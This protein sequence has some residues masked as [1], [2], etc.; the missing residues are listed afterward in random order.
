LSTTQAALTAHLVKPDGRLDD[1]LLARVAEELR[2]RFGIAHATIQLEQGAAHTC[3]LGPP[4][5]GAVGR[6]EQ[7]AAPDRRGM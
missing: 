4:T 6:A 2:A 5:P 7:G 3:S 1:E